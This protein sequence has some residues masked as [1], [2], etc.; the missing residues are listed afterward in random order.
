[1]PDL[2][3]MGKIIGGGLPVGAY[4]GRADIMDHIL[5]AGKVFQAGTLSGNPLATAAGI[6]TLKILRDTNPYAHLQRIIRTLGQGIDGC[7]RR[8]RHSG[9][10]RHVRRD[11]DIVFQSGA[12]RR[13]DHG[14]ALQYPTLRQIF[15]GPYRTWNLHA[16]QPIRGLFPLHRPYRRRY[17]RHHRRG[18]RSFCRGNSTL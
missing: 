5:P 13:L 6:A 17:R 10:D 18:E 3:T 1:M 4:G 15:L 11:D 12:G 2:T 9:F 14:L 8:N 16:V 7:R